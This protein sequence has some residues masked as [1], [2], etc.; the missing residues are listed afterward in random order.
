MTG[1]HGGATRSRGA[2]VLLI[3]GAVLLLHATAPQTDGAAPP[4]TI[5][6]L[7]IPPPLSH[8][9]ARALNAGP[10]VHENPC[11]EA[12]ERLRSLPGVRSLRTRTIGL[13]GRT[14]VH[15]LGSHGTVAGGAIEPRMLPGRS[16]E[17]GVRLRVDSAFRRG[18][19][20]LARVWRSRD[21]PSET[22]S[23]NTGAPLA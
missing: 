12:V 16:W 11:P 10:P 1:N 13:P 4:D 6:V 23:M 21:R 9:V 19:R 5:V 14:V 20:W 15:V 22:G 3:L 18:E 2:G 17:P 8:T 7:G